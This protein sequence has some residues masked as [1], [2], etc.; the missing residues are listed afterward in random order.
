MATG[1]NQVGRVD[2]SRPYIPSLLVHYGIRST[3]GSEK[4]HPPCQN[5][6]ADTGVICDR[7]PAQPNSPHLPLLDRKNHGSLAE[8]ESML[9]AFGFTPHRN[10]V[11]VETVPE[12]WANGDHPFELR[13]LLPYA[14]IRQGL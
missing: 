13:L 1:L 11:W 9:P 8:I 2:Y 5:V 12:I 6:L 14:L 3:S 10:W 4:T 7:I